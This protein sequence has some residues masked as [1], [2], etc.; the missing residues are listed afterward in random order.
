MLLALG[1]NPRSVWATSPTDVACLSQPRTS[2]SAG[3]R[4]MGF[5]AT[6]ALK[7]LGME[8]AFTVS[9]H[10][11]PLDATGSGDQITGVGAIA[12]PFG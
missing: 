2:V 8:L 7:D 6:I 10:V 5:I 4:E 1:V 12:I 3:S 11:D 9:G